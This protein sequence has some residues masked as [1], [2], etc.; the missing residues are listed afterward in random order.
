MCVVTRDAAARIL[1]AVVCAP[2]TRTIRGVR[3][4]VEIGPE[5]GL[6]D[7]CAVN[8]DSLVTI[9]VHSLD[10]RAVGRLDESKRAELDRA[11]RYALDI[12]Y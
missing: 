8:C 9:P 6:G 5:Q 11:L 10:R 2:V 1:T 3:S 12:L 7:R 4:E